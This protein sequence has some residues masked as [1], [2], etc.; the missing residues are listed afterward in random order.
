MVSF[1]SHVCVDWKVVETSTVDRLGA[2]LGG[3][4]APSLVLRN[5]C[6]AL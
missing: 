2:N 1:D 4:L 5:I 3:K 6:N